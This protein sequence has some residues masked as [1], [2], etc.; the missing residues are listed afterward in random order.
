MH[1]CRTCPRNGLFVFFHGTNCSLPNK[2]KKHL[3]TVS[4]ETRQEY[5]G[6]CRTHDNPMAKMI[7][8]LVI[9]SDVG[10]HELLESRNL[11]LPFGK[12]SLSLLFHVS[13]SFCFFFCHFARTPSHISP[14]LAASPR[15][16]AAARRTAVECQQ[17]DENK[18]CKT[19]LTRAS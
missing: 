4:R 13:L 7:T 9:V 8:T 3:E 18:R 1:N 10:V 15:L 6:L 14:F 17:T 2:Q 12:S 16:N 19:Q 5:Q 11:F